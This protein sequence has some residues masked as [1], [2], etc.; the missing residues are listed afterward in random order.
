M[1]ANS[2][3]AIVSGASNPDTSRS[4]LRTNPPEPTSGAL[5][6]CWIINHSTSNAHTF[7]F[8]AVSWPPRW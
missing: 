8:G 5:N 4:P 7:E 3:A 2:S 1:Y 6:I